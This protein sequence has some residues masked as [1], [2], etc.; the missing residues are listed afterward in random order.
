MAVKTWQPIV[1]TDDHE[2]FWKTVREVK[3][4]IYSCLLENQVASYDDKAVKYEFL[5][6]A[7]W[8]NKLMWGT[9]PG[10]YRNFAQQAVLQCEGTILDVGC[11]GL[12]HT[13][14]IYAKAPNPLILLDYS[15]E[16]LRI[17]RKRLIKTGYKPFSLEVPERILFLQADAFQLPFAN[18]TI[19]HLVSFGMLHLFD[20]KQEYISSL[21]RVLK[22]GG[23]FFFS[24]LTID[25]PLSR[26]YYQFLYKKKEMGA[27]LTSSEIV[28]LFKT[29]SSDIRY[30][31]VGSMVFV[32]GIKNKPR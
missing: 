12:S 9:T 29:Y 2:R 3:D 18:E 32:S 25:R 6:S 13:T 16:M 7:W 22:Q 21:M 30:Y 17:A 4:G 1:A 19:D 5:V 23:R 24:A 28:G 8:Y 31:T 15:I 11:G 10:A 20:H 27:P 14:G 26:K